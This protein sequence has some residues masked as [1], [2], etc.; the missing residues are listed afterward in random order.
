MR[1]RCKPYGRSI[2]MCRLKRPVFKKGDLVEQLWPDGTW[3]G[4][5]DVVREW[6]RKGHDRAHMVHLCLRTLRGS[7]I[8]GSAH[9]HQ[10][11]P[12]RATTVW[13]L[14]RPTEQRA[15]AGETGA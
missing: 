1:C 12:L 6:R 7:R 11:R 9:A 4:P 2:G 8:G 5:F 3:R 10:V 15:R 13:G 14:P